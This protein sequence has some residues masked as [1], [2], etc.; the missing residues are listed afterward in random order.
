MQYPPIQVVDLGDNP[1]SGASLQ[2]V[3]SKGLHHRVIRVLLYDDQGNV[4][5][6]KRAKHMKTY[7]DLWDTSSAGYVDCGEDYKSAATRELHEELGIKVSD[8]QE[9]MKYNVHRNLGDGK[10]R[11]FETIFKAT[12]S[13]S[14]TITIEPKEVSEVRWFALND[15]LLLIKNSPEQVT[16]GL[17][18]VVSRNGI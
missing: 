2:E 5:L 6:Q 7:P 1:I 15:V 13:R 4:L 10:Y 8:L 16:Y 14:A 9:V 3:V 12:I 11:R 18:E 17:K